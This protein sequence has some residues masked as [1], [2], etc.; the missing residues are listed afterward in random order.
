MFCF[1]FLK[2]RNSTNAN[3]S[4]SK[5]IAVACLQG[6]AKRE[7]PFEK[8]KFWTRRGREDLNNIHNRELTPN[9]VPGHAQ[10]AQMARGLGQNQ[11]GP[12][13]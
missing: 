3:K 9:P 4:F 12:G 6:T 1:L 10:L 8:L 11:R 7:W 2:V 5:P 13:F